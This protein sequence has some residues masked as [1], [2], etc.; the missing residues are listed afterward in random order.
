[1][2]LGSLPPSSLIPASSA[3]VLTDVPRAISMHSGNASASGGGASRCILQIP[4]KRN[5]IVFIVQRMMPLIIMGGGA[6]MVRNL[7]SLLA[8][9]NP[10]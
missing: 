6:L 8:H 7:A 5:A 3:W 2:Q 9:R 10:L 4:I 1:M